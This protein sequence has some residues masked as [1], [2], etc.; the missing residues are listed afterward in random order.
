MLKLGKS[1]ETGVVGHPKPGDSAQHPTSSLVNSGHGGAGPETQH[2]DAG[3]LPTRRP[4]A[5][6]GGACAGRVSCGSSGSVLSM[7]AS[8]A[9]LSK[10]GQR[11]RW[12]ASFV[13]KLTRAGVRAL[14]TRSE[15][16][17]HNSFVSFKGPGTVSHQAGS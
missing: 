6:P 3:Q 16:T 1:E 11:G 7:C 4:P 14:L 10:L 17:T 13:D 15:F 2:R 5:G 8:L 12:E 9:F